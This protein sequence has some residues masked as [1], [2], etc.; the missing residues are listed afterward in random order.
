MPVELSNMEEIT[1]VGKLNL[2]L[3]GYEQNGKSILATTAR[4]PILFHEF[5]GKKETLRGKPGVFVLS[6]KDPQWPNQPTAAQD[7]LTKIGQL[8]NS[9]D[10]PDLGFGARKEPSVTTTA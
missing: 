3:I 1:Q 7:F 9:I 6:Y 2:A 5:D 4:K 8:E 10:L